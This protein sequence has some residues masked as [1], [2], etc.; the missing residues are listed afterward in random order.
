MIQTPVLAQGARLW[1]GVL[2]HLAWRTRVPREALLTEALAL[3][4]RGAELL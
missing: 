4:R 3:K 2:A 1:P